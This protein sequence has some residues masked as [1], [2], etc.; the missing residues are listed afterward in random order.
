MVLIDPP[1]T[2]LKIA[3]V[4]VLIILIALGVGVIA[5]ASVVRLRRR[6]ATKRWKARTLKVRSSGS[7]DE[8][9]KDVYASEKEAYEAI[10]GTRSRT[11]SLVERPPAAGE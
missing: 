7:G 3:A 9:K 2:C 4:L 6:Q 5:L 8:R 11:V 10:Y 1:P